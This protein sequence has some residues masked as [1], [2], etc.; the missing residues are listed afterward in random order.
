MQRVRSLEFK[1]WE[2]VPVGLMIKSVD[3]ILI[4]KVSFLR[5]SGRFFVYLKTPGTYYSRGIK[6]NVRQLRKRG[7]FFCSDDK[8]AFSSAGADVSQVI[9]QYVCPA[10]L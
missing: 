9:R 7:V 3:L 8:T 10:F 1:L 6:R 4:E 5:W 2:G